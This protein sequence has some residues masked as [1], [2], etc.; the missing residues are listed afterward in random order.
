MATITS[1]P[2]PK[3]W[4]RISVSVHYDEAGKMIDWL[5]AAFG[6]E[7]RLRVDGEGGVV[8]HA[9]LTLG[10]GLIMTGDARKAERPWRK[11]PKELGASTMSLCVYVD[12]VESHCARARAAGATIAKEPT[13][14]DYGEEYWTDRGYEA[15]DPEGHHWYFVQRLK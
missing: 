5:G 15:I 3:G 12:D 10:E 7:V 11:T 1:K 4:P 6:F 2:S 13:T 8:E 9:E 14:T